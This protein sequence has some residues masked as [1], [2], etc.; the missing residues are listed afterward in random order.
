MAVVPLLLV[1]VG[2][3][4]ILLGAWMS[5]RTW[6]ATRAG[7]VGVRP[8]SPEGVLTGLAKLLEAMKTYPPGQQM[9][10]FGLLLVIVGG[11]WG[12]ITPLSAP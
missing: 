4:L 7:Q 3:L 2:V 6:Q 10:V 12:G 5:L 8:E 1:G 11:L 9:I